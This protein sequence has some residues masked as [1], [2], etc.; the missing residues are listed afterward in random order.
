MAKRAPSARASSKEIWERVSRTHRLLHVRVIELSATW[1]FY[2]GVFG[3]KRV[4]NNMRQV[5]PT[6][7]AFVQRALVNDV[8]RAI[9]AL[10]D[11]ASSG[12]GR[13]N[14]SLRAIVDDLQAVLDNTRTGPLA[15][16]LAKIDGMVAVLRKLRNKRLMHF[17]YK[18]IA[19]SPRSLTPVLAADLK[20][21]I[22]EIGDL[23]ANIGLLLGKQCVAYEVSTAPQASGQ[24]DWMLF[25]TLRLTKLRRIATARK[26]PDA[27]IRRLVSQRSDRYDEQIIAGDPTFP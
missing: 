19:S 23:L 4:V 27:V 8:V 2:H 6:G 16:Q 18:T 11:V 24:W 10:T 14:A 12:S 13:Q 25:D 3:E 17:D 1:N 7:F 21:A 20:A 5:S 9:Y 22:R 26:L 15:T